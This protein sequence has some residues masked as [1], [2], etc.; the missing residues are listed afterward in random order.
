M[1]ESGAS[2]SN[3]TMQMPQMG[4]E[5][6]NGSSQMPNERGGQKGNAFENAFTAP[7][8]SELDVSLTAPDVL[9]LAGLTTLI[10]TAATLLPALYILRLSPREILVRKEG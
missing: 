8:N 3:V 7:Q 1:L 6:Q 4:M 2:N 5:S 10:C 9:K